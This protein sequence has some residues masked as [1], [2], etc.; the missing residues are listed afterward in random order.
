MIDAAK[1]FFRTQAADMHEEIWNIAREIG[2]NPELGYEEH[3]ASEL[4]CSYLREQGFKVEKGIGGLETAFIA[5]FPGESMG[6][7]IVFL[8]EYDALPGI[9]HGCGHN[10]IGAASVGA[11][12]VLSKSPSLP[13]EVLVMGTPAEETSGAKI[14]LVELG[15][16]KDIDIALMFHPGSQNVPQ[17]STLAL[18]AWEFVFLGRSAHAVAASRY[19][20]NAL[21]ALIRFFSDVNELKADCGKEYKINGIITEGGTTPNVIPDRAVARFYLRSE[22]RKTLDDLSERVIRCALKA[23]QSQ[24]AKVEWRKFEF[25]YNEMRSNQV[26]AG[27][28]AK[29]LHELGVRNIYPQQNALGSVDMGN[30]SHVVPAI[31]PYLVLGKGTDVPHTREFAGAVVGEEGKKLLLLAIEALALTGWD[32]LS[33]SKLLHKIKQ[34][35]KRNQEEG[36]L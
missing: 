24:G 15:L 29:N 21:D 6:P 17:I 3:Y 25:S 1:N 33:D 11:A 12:A 16:F 4:L 36:I 7:R 13:G 28:F 34:E 2:Q 27:C 22:H 10:L 8:A 19:G 23:A 18:D 30:V 32:V 35:F 5:R 31:H 14:T 9:G 26:L 20:I